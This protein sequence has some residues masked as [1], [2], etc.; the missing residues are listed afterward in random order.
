MT[1]Y[2]MVMLPPTLHKS[3]CEKCLHSASPWAQLLGFRDGPRGIVRK[4]YSE[5]TVEA[6]ARPL[7]FPANMMNLSSKRDMSW[8]LSR[9][10]RRL[11][12]TFGPI[13]EVAF[14][15]LVVAATLAG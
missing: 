10:T 1:A 14:K 4:V 6:M 11:P 7:L 13:P 9:A 3:I 12:C 15:G 2:S 8:L 5:I